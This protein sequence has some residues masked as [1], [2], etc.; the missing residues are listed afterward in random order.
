MDLPADVGIKHAVTV[1]SCA[2]LA[3]VLLWIQ[4]YARKYASVFWVDWTLSF[5]RENT[6]AKDRMWTYLHLNMVKVHMEL[7]G[8]I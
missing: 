7:K 2:L 4:A 6:P 3:S 8:P 5:H 1:R